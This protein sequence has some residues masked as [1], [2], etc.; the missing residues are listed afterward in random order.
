VRSARA[1]VIAVLLA[2]P[3]IAQ[4]QT[5][6]RLIPQPREI[7]VDGTISL[8]DGISI[9]PASNEEDRF[10]ASDLADALKE[11][12]IRVAASAAMAGAAGTRPRI[13]LLRSSAP[14]AQS[15]LRRHSMELG[16]AMRDEGYV[17]V[18]DGNRINVIGASAPGVFYGAQ[19]V[20]QLIEGDG[21]GARIHRATVRDWPAMRYRGF[22][23]DLSRGPMPTLDF[24][25]KQLRTLAAYKINVF[26]PYFENMLQY[27]SNPLPAPPGGAAGPAP[28]QGRPRT[29]VRAKGLRP[30]SRLKTTGD[31]RQCADGR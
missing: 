6:P 31:A 25:K 4:A 7:S 24:Q 23:D 29:Q 1:G 16:D 13:T 30:R 26:S 11:R 12:G 2:A 17:I 15:L 27:L 5:A 21:A 14:A 3:L 8:R 20:K 28:A 18:S 22:H 10:A 19:T 9:A